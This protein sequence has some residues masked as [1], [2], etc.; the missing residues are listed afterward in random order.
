MTALSPVG[1]THRVCILSLRCAPGLQKEIDSL[2]DGFRRNGWAATQILA[3]DYGAFRPE[4]PEVT[5]VPLRRGYAGMLRDAWAEISGKKL[6]Q[7][8]IRLQPDLVL[9]Y[10]QSPLNLL[11]MRLRK[12]NPACRFGFF[13]HDPWKARKFS[14]GPAYAFTYA[15]VEKLQ[16]Q[17]ARQ[18]DFVVTLSNWGT[19]LVRVHYPEGTGV[20]VE[21]RILLPARPEPGPGARSVVSIIGR[22]NPSTGHDEFFSL[23]SGIR[24]QC[25]GLSFEV[26]TSSA[27]ACD[28][29]FLARAAASGVAINYQPVL[30]ENQIEAAVA[31]SLCVFRMDDELTQSGVVPVCYRAGTPVVA[32]DIPGLRQHVEQGRTGFILGP[33]TLPATLTGWLE[34]MRVNQARY[35][36]DCRAAFLA[37]WDDRCFERYY[38]ALLQA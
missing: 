34:D 12:H 38:G 11:L 3:E 35:Q 7:L 18:C 9:F 10:N 26:V 30:S 17:T 32:R 4:S 21:G 36:A 6:Q 37:H 22:I 29:G 19:E 20:R 28:P 23:V 16:K 24:G 33:E 25:P 13:L 31:R 1:E 8:L 14:Y 5:F 15:A 27:A 2:C